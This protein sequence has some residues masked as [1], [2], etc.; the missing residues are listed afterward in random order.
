VERIERRYIGKKPKVIENWP[1]G[2]S[3]NFDRQSLD[4]YIKVSASGWKK[5]YL[6]LGNCD[7]NKNHFEVLNRFKNDPYTQILHLGDM[8]QIDT[9]ESSLI[10]SPNVKLLSG[11]S[12]NAI[13]IADEVIVP[14][15]LEA[16]SMVV[17]ESLLMRKPVHVRKSW[18][19]I[20][21]EI[22]KVSDSIVSD[23]FIKL[24]EVKDY[25]EF[26]NYYNAERGIS[27]YMKIYGIP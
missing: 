8:S 12:W 25:E 14:S 5:K 1:V 7:I 17:L 4:S 6:L 16:S 19:T 18:G 11:E 24:I 22:C 23:D 13:S 21:T 20:Y 3:E 27:E 10:G 9:E 2:I 26:R 15:I